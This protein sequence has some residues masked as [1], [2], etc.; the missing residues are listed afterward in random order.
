QQG[1]RYSSV[2]RRVVCGE[3]FIESVQTIEI[4]NEIEAIH[5]AVRGKF[6]R[7]LLGGNSFFEASRP[8]RHLREA[9]EA[10]NVVGIDLGEQTE[11]VGGFFVFL[12]RF[13][14]FGENQIALA[15]ADV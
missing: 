12:G 13:I 7:V 4:E 8:K 10:A 11:L 2:S 1:T 9:S 5:S 3:G 6:E 15:F 14:V